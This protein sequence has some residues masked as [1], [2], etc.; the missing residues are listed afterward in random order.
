MICQYC[1]KEAKLVTGKRIYPK[2]PDLFNKNY[3]LCEPCFAYVGCHDGSD[4]PKGP[5][6]NNSLRALRRD[7]HFYFDKTWK[8]SVT[9]RSSAYK[10]LSEKLKIKPEQ[11]HIGMFDERLCEKTINLVRYK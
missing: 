6:A 4:R 8:T 10:W 1:N 9:S 3:Y 7:V 2:R 11:C 5:L